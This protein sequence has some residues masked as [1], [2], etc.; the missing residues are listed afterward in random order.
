MALNPRS[1]IRQAALAVVVAGASLLG[2]SAFGQD[3]QKASQQV[4]VNSPPQATSLATHCNDIKAV[5][6]AAKMSYGFTKPYEDQLR[7]YFKDGCKGDFPA[8]IAKTDIDN[9]RTATFI[10][11]R[12][13]NID[14]G[15]KFD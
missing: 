6:I 15:L 8:P 1:T 14:I 10:L 13:G 5:F 9:V 7:S 11:N 12:G 3:V 4:A 2:S